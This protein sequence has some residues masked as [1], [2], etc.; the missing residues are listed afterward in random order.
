MFKAAVASSAARV[1]GYKRLGVA[2]TGKKGPWW[3][4]NMKDAIQAKKAACKAL[5]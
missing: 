2:N 4:Q 5:F 3:N 1:C